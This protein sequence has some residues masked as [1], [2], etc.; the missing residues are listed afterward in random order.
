MKTDHYRDSPPPSGGGVPSV[1]M[2]KIEI[3]NLAELELKKIELN[4]VLITEQ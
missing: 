4:G 3:S 2:I 1:G